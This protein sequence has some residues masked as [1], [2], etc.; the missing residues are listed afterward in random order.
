[1]KQEPES[2]KRLPSRR[3]ADDLRASIERGDLASGAKLP[4]ERDLAAQYGTARNT[5]REA[6]SILQKEGLVVAQP[7]RGVFVRPQQPL[8]RLGSNRY[9]RRLR[10]ETGLSPFRIEVTKQGRTPK[11]ECRSVTTEQAL[12]E[13][14]DRL[15]LEAENATVV[16]RENWYYADDEPV[17]VG[18][19]YIP[20]EV[21][22]DSPLA[23]AKTLG[24][25]SI[26]ARFE[27]LGYP[28]A[29][30]REEISARMP[31]PDEMTGLGMPPGVPVIEVLHTGFDEQRRPF[32]VTR[33]VMRGDLNGLDYDMPVED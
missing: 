30:I 1:M 6:I 27:E 23:S 9:S 10:G 17:Q 2:D 20:I 28:I 22:G 5:A 7:G 32:E 4:S 8:M 18:V 3:I 25:G 12:A 19:T 13:V 33:F 31:N 14:A 29:R 24:K 21:A 15:G 11:T 16:R 26:Y